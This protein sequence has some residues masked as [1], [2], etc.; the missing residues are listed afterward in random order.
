MS[1]IVGLGEVLWDLLPEGKV[2]GGAPLNFTF[3]CKQ[4]GQPAVMVSRVGTDALGEQIRLALRAHGLE[5]AWLQADADHPT[6]TVTVQLDPQ[7]QPSYTIHEGVAWDH[8]AWTDALGSLAASARAVCFGTLMQR[9]QTSRTTVQRFLDQAR[10]ALIVCDINLRQH[11]HSREVLEASLNRSHWIK[12]NDGELLYL[13]DLLG[14]AGSSESALVTSLRQRYQADV[15]ALTRGAHGCLVQ[16]ADK[17]FEEPGISVQVV[18]TVGAGDAFTA[19]LLVRHLEG[20]SL[21]EAARFANRLA[22]QV[23]RYPGGTP[24]IDRAT[25]GD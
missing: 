21:R 10:S 3:H 1:V 16:T 11:Y 12:L 17:E 7:G 8:L 23:A 19:G 24:R 25:L 22:A 4:L 13:R 14:L 15:V 6:S 18:D 2:L 9:S 5:D 20:A